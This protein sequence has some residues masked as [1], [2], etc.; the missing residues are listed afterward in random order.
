MKNLV[1][2][3]RGFTKEE[4]QL[5]QLEIAAALGIPCVFIKYGPEVG[6]YGLGQG[7]PLVTWASD[8]RQF[9]DCEIVTRS[10]LRIMAQ[11]RIRA[12]TTAT[13]Y[14]IHCELF[15]AK[16]DIVSALRA[17]ASQEGA[18]G[19]EYDLMIQAANYIE[20]LRLELAKG[21]L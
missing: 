16:V 21:A 19:N 1:I 3:V 12:L 17:T 11:D 10:Q 15:H 13:P 7:H 6:A 2:N 5:V 14:P 9:H 18:D 20:K 4:K 8:A